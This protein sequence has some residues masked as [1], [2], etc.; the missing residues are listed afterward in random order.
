[1]PSGG[2]TLFLH[3]LSPSFFWAE[4]SSVALNNVGGAA[5]SAL[6]AT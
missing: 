5:E 4:G 6:D 1:M 3:R 2:A